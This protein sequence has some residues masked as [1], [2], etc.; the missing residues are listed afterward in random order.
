MAKERTLPKSEPVTVPPFTGISMP[1]ADSPFIKTAARD[2]SDSIIRREI[3]ALRKRADGLEKLVAVL[4]KDPEAA[5]AE[6][7]LWELICASRSKA[8][9]LS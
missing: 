2:T 9:T 1:N 4:S 3:T 6:A 7:V 8:G 5:H